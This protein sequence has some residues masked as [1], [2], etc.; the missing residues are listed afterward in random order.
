MTDTDAGDRAPGRPWSTTS[1]LLDVRG[2][3][4]GGSSRSRGAGSRCRG[5]MPLRAGPF[6]PIGE[7][8]ATLGLEPCSG[9]ALRRGDARSAWRNAAVDELRPFTQAMWH[10]AST[11][12]RGRFLRHL[13]PVVDVHRHR[14]A[15]QVVGTAARDRRARPARGGGRESARARRAARRRF[16]RLAPRGGDMAEMMTVQRIVI[17]TGL[18]GDLL[19]TTE[20]PLRRLA[21]RGPSG[22]TRRTSA[23]MSSN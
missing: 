1:L 9:S 16:G 20:P 17:C 11:A 15:P 2:S 5:C 3:T 12:E 4:S 10:N 23:S 21:E 22:P 18:Q 7:R 6:E 14:L 13:R 8:P 19:R